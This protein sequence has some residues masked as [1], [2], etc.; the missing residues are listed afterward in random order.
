MSSV[1]QYLRS[2]VDFVGC[3]S[4]SSHKTVAFQTHFKNLGWNI[5]VFKSSQDALRLALSS[6]AKHALIM[7]DTVIYAWPEND[8][9]RE[10]DRLLDKTFDIIGVGSCSKPVR[11]SVYKKLEDYEFTYDTDCVCM[12]AVIYSNR[13]MQ[14]LLA[15]KG[16]ASGNALA[17]DPPLFITT[18]SAANNVA[19][20]I[21]YNPY[22]LAVMAYKGGSWALPGSALLTLLILWLVTKKIWI[23]SK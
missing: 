1:P 18:E 6:G 21:V 4:T 8:V 23:F 22:G 13:F 7:D 2:L 3:V 14:Q 11:C 17:I 9:V 16:G 12:H 19:T 5:P 10:L 20:E 15:S